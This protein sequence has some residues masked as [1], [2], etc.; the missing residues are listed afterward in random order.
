MDIGTA[1]AL[2]CVKSRLARRRVLAVR[3]RQ[4]AVSGHLLANALDLPALQGCH[5]T[6]GDV[7]VAILGGREPHVH[8]LSR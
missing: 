6:D 8:E 1:R 3:V 7:Y 5:G 2:S 4:A